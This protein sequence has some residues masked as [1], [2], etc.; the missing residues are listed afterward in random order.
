M[1][2]LSQITV[3]EYLN[4]FVIIFMVSNFRVFVIFRHFISKFQSKTDVIINN[5]VPEH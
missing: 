5:G 1:M 4:K 3:F 2:V